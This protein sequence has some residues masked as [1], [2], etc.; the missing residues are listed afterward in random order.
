MEKT[1]FG[2]LILH[3][4]NSDLID[5]KN[6]K[7]IHINPIP[8]QAELLKFYREEFYQE[9][10][11]TY[12]KKDEEEI[13]YWNISYDEKLSILKSNDLP[14]KRI[15]DIGCGGGFFLR[16]AKEKGFEVLGIE[17]SHHASDYAKSHNIPIITE[18]FENVDF[19]NHKKFGAIHMNAV[20]EHSGSPNQ[21]LEICHNILEK[22]GML[23]VE[24]PNDFNPLQKIVQKSLKKDEWWVAPKEH[25]N[26]FNFNSLSEL[27]QRKG[28]QVIKK[29]ATFPLEMYLLM[30]FDYI[31]DSDVGLK[32]HQERMEFEE[33]M[34]KG[35][36]QKLK[37]E[38]YSK[39]AEIG[40]GRR[41]IIFA[42]K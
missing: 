19:T 18:F 4:E 25:L 8:S 30:G 1:H 23:I 32:K 9:V 20:L 28:F 3:K 6:C 29:Q 15:L 7:F 17:P 38:I 10:K 36:G 27:I 14:N 22:N 13:E 31:N 21:I 11:P 26:Y 24:T 12:L 2:D 35:G 37:Q 5:C 42:K 34:T 33:N 16:R 41:A 40:I 39:F